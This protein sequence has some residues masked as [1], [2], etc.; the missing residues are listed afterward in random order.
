MKIDCNKNDRKKNKIRQLTLCPVALA[1]PRLCRRLG[2]CHCF[3]WTLP[4]FQ[5]EWWTVGGQDR[6]T[7]EI[8]YR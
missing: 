3:A 4:S 7:G 5:Q 6:W 8:T 1:R 2:T